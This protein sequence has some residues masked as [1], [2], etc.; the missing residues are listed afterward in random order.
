MGPSRNIELIG[1]AYFEV[2]HNSEKPFI[3][4]SGTQKVEVLGTSFNISS[5]E[6]DSCIMTTLVEGLVKVENSLQEKLNTHLR[7]NQQSILDKKAD[8][9]KSQNVNVDEYVAWQSGWFRFN[10]KPISQIM[11]ILA[12]WYDLEVQ[13]ESENISNKHF[14]GGFKRY[15]SFDQ[16]RKII[17][18]TG[19]IK[20]EV[21]GKKVIIL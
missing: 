20:F 19:E 6:R 9:I 12:R 13:F 2:T 16:A 14:S 7:P 3:I 10:D 15:D 18:Q 11:V 4:T 21:K 8:S 1:E 5:Y 17:E